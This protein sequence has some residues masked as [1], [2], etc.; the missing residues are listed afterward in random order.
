MTTS[1]RTS[2]RWELFRAL[3]A[4]AEKPHHAIAVS[5]GLG[6]GLAGA[7][8]TDVFTFTAPPYASVYL[9]AEGML[10]GEAAARVAGFWQAVGYAPPHPPDH[11][12][13]LLGLYATLG[14]RESSAQG[15]ES[16]LLGQGRRALLWE[17]LLG[18]TGVFCDVIRDAGISPWDRWADLVEEAL[19]EVRDDQMA[20]A[21]RLPRHLHEA[22]PPLDTSSQLRDLLI[23]VRAGIV[24]TRA[25]LARLARRLGLG[26]RLSGR[27]PTLETLAGQ[28]RRQ[29]LHWLRDHANGWERRHRARSGP[30]V[31]GRFWADRAANTSAAVDA[32]LAEA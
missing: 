20:D 18:W 14:E 19:T 32:M 10:G 7:D 2:G 13:A 1:I 23:P 25:D 31:I 4:L 5:L 15:A 11:L 28:S 24:I 21:G 29:V 8:H 9:G 16:A 22:P 26:I 3:G 12:A 6:D 17:H 27:L 30:A